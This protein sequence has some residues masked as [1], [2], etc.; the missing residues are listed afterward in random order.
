MK[1]PILWISL[2][3]IGLAAGAA[4]WPRTGAE[5]PGFALLTD[6]EFARSGLTRLTDE[7][8]DFLAGFWAGPPVAD[9]TVGSA[10]AYLLEEGWTYIT[11]H[12]AFDPG[13]AYPFADVLQLAYIGPEAYLVE[14][15]LSRETLAPGLY[16]VDKTGPILEII[17]P[18]GEG[19]RYT[20]EKEL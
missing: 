20:I 10:T 11:L 19:I 7:E 14:P 17:D 5:H 9:F 12:G 6:E 15:T 2:V 8:L 16:L 3:A 13:D 18:R 4:A 1:T